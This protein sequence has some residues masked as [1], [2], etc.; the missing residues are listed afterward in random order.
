MK[1]VDTIITEI[2]ELEKEKEQTIR[3]ARKRIKKQK[4]NL[5]TQK[6]QIQGA[7]SDRWVRAG[8]IFM[9]GIVVMIAFWCIA[10][11]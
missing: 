3:D 4:E 2:D 10:D 9:V 7:K 1:D 6:V 11:L 5:K 8:L